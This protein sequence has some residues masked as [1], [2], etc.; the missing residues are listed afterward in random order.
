MKRLLATLVAV[1]LLA[2]LVAG[3][4]SG[5][6]SSGAG[7]AASSREAAAAA[8]TP[9]VAYGVITSLNRAFEGQD[10]A[11][12]APTRLIGCTL[13]DAPACAAVPQA[14]TDS[15]AIAVFEG[16]VYSG[17]ASGK[18]ISCPAPTVTSD[19]CNAVRASGAPVTGLAVITGT[20]GPDTGVRE[21]LLY[22]VDTGG[23]W[24][25]NVK[26]GGCTS[27]NRGA[28]GVVV[29][30]GSKVLTT[31]AGA[32]ALLSCDTT[33]TSTD[34]SGMPRGVR[35]MA[36][37]GDSVLVGGNSTGSLVGGMIAVSCPSAGGACTRFTLPGEDL[38][39][40]WGA[41]VT[42][43]P[44]GTIFVASGTGGYYNDGGALSTC[45]GSTCTSVSTFTRAQGGSMFTAVAT[46][47]N[48]FVG[49]LASPILWQCDA[50]GANC[51]KI[52]STDRTGSTTAVSTIAVGS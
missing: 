44:G 45:S 7:T 18:V 37:A 24:R 26:G 17:G 51:A 4:G 6:T 32:T 40:S 28:R 25:C 33:C 29:A 16:R 12:D 21:T 36:V 13:G 34:V 47:A 9:T 20:S 1:P 43:S 49:G 19:S 38:P 2:V 27:I 14:G 42:V 52:Y 11:K 5:D 46:D 39:T 8:A 23:L 3:C 30:A 10:A 41:G 48:V 22:I 35:S 15:S 50:A 31:N